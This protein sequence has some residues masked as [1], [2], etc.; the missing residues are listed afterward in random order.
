MDTLI[1]IYK[2]SPHTSLDHTNETDGAHA[3]KTE[4][5]NKYEK[6]EI[7]FEMFL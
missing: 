2:S 7:T 4:E 6:I 3:Q 1:R 5:Q